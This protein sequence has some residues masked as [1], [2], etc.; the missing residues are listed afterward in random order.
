MA[1]LVLGAVACGSGGTRAGLGVSCSLEKRRQGYVMSCE[2][3]RSTDTRVEC[4]LIVERV[5]KSQARICERLLCA[6]LEGVT[7]ARGCCVD[8]EGACRSD[9]TG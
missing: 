5:R 3:E 8:L 9:A 4:L 6:D 1:P 2:E 7:S